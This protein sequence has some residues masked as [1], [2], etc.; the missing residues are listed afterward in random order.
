MRKPRLML[1]LTV[2]AAASGGGAIGAVLLPAGLAALA[3]PAA[4]QEKDTEQEQE[5][6]REHEQEREQESDR[7]TDVGIDREMDREESRSDI[8]RDNEPDVV[9]AIDLSDQAR[10][11]SH[12]LG[13]RVV[14]E[15]TLRGLGFRL[16]QLSTPGGIPPE[17]AVRRLR[18]ADPQGIYDVNSRYSAAGE[19]ACAGIRCDAQKTIGWPVDGCKAAAR[20]GM[21]DTAVAQNSPALA[22]SHVQQRHFG[23]SGKTPEGAEHGTEVATILAG[24]AAAGFA[25]LTPN[26]TLVAADVF[27]FSRERGEST[28][29]ALV[30]LGMDWLLTQN[31]DVINVSIAGPDNGVLRET[32]RRVA[33][34]GVPLVAAAGN[35]GPA[36]PPQYPA[37]YPEAIAVTAVDRDGRIYDRAS[38]GDYIDIAAPGV[39]IWSAGADGRGRFVDGTSFAVPFVTAEIAMGRGVA[40]NQATADWK[41]QLRKAALPAAA[42]EQRRIYGAGILRSHACRTAE[43]QQAAAPHGR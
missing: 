22:G 24:N 31:P 14:A 34:R 4:A 38:Q 33:Q 41:E 8:G 37:A 32:V 43:A 28:S 7:E 5:V 30:A 25:G 13:F 9:L 19:D 36:G 20:I 12:K 10:A 15:D 40:L 39:H 1:A 18:L 23:D 26:A 35:L 29:A 6:E 17:L 16:T 3:P 21:I 42:P 11:A 27:D 2:F